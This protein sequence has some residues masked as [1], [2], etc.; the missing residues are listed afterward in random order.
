MALKAST[1]LRNAMLVTGSLKS[2]LDGGFI[3]IYAGSV[4]ADA[5]AAIGSATVLCTITQDGDGSTGL[6]LAAT[7]ASGAVSKANEVWAGTNDS[8]GTATFWRFYK[9]GDTGALSTTAIRLQGI[10]ATSGAELILTS[11]ALAGGA[12]QNIDYFSVALPS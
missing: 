9:T 1:G 2:Q 5:D 10:A 7:A 6:T 12:Q 8:S 11:T 3:D 4:P